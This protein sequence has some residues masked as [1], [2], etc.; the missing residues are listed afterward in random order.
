MYEALKAETMEEFEQRFYEYQRTATTA[1]KHLLSDA[2]DKIGETNV[3]LEA[4]K[5]DLRSDI[6]A[7]RKDLESV[8]HPDPGEHHAGGSAPSDRSPRGDELGPIG[9]HVDSTYRGQGQLYVPPPVRDAHDSQI[10]SKIHRS[11]SNS[12]ELNS[13][14]RELHSDVSSTFPRDLPRFDG[15]NPRL[16]QTRCEDSFQLWGTTSTY[17]ISLAT[18]QF[19]GPAARWLESVQ[20]RYPNVSWTEFC[21]LLLGRFGRNQHQGLLCT[22]FR[23]SQTST[24]ADYVERFSELIDQLS[25][26]ESAP[27][28]LHYVTRFLDGLKPSVRVLVAIQQPPDLDTAYELALLHEELGDGR[29]YCNSHWEPVASQHRAQG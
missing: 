18:A 13:E 16:W 2:V 28:P 22:L 26:Y 8:L 21:V 11:A 27:D 19:E 24:V 15:S 9:H 5:I 4:V 14:S 6:G 25:A 12:R 7:L 3:R 29:N 17:W 23:I 1:F 10:P 20:R